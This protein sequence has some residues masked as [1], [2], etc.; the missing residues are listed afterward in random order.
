MLKKRSI[1]IL[2]LVER[3]SEISMFVSIGVCIID[4]YTSK[5]LHTTINT[6][7]NRNGYTQMEI[8]EIGNPN[9]WL[10]IQKARITRLWVGV[11]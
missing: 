4:A 6:S 11:A 7:Q 10:K 1:A 2:S 9:G 8:G 3:D 5:K